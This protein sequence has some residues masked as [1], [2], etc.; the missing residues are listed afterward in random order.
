[1]V[2][3]PEKGEPLERYAETLF[4]LADTSSDK[5]IVQFRGQGYSSRSLKNA[6]KTHKKI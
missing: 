5:L 3:L 2:I 6:Q 1:M 4:D